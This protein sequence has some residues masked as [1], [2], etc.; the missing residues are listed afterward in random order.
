M[1]IRENGHQSSFEKN[2]LIDKYSYRVR[3]GYHTYIRIRLG[4]IPNI[5]MI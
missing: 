3:L 2:T 4:F 1:H 5:N